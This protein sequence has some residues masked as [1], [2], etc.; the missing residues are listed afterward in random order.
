MQP[1]GNR[2]P[3][4]W[5]RRLTGFAFGAAPISGLSMAVYYGLGWPA[6]TG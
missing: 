4:P 6:G 3:R 5:L 2:Q 1:I